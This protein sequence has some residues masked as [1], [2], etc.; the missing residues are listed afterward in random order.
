MNLVGKMH[1]RGSRLR[2]NR[3]ATAPVTMAT[4]TV[5]TIPAAPSIHPKCKPEI[6]ETAIPASNKKPIRKRAHGKPAPQ[7]TAVEDTTTSKSTKENLSRKDKDSKNIVAD[8]STPVAVSTCAVC[9]L[10]R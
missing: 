6:T 5:S 10:V 2:R 4:T 8:T 7:D 1:P 3:L 9:D